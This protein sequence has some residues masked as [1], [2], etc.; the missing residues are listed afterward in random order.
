MREHMLISIIAMVGFYGLI[1]I[2]QDM[3]LQPRYARTYIKHHL[4]HGTNASA[5]DVEEHSPSIHIVPTTS[6]AV[7]IRIADFDSSQSYY[8]D[9]GNGVRTRLTS[10]YSSY[11]IEESDPVLIKFFK[12]DELIE[13]RENVLNL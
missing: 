3:R 4:S 2:Y 9:L 10:P 6:S 12:N 13:A 7:N 5:E 8:M 11:D 1:T